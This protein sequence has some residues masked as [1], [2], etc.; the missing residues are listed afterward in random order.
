MITNSINIYSRKPH[1]PYNGNRGAEYQFLQ[2]LKGK[3]EFVGMIKGRDNSIYIRFINIL[4][5]IKSDNKILNAIE[6]TF[7]KDLENL[8]E[9]LNIPS[10]NKY[11]SIKRK[12][13]KLSDQ[14]IYKKISQLI[15]EYGIIELNINV[16]KE[17][18]SD[19]V[20]VE[21]SYLLQTIYHRF[22]NP[23]LLA[24]FYERFNKPHIFN[25]FFH[26]PNDL[27]LP[28]EYSM[29]SGCV[30]IFRIHNNCQGLLN[31]WNRYLPNKIKNDLGEF[32]SKIKKILKNDEH[33]YENSEIRN[34]IIKNQKNKYRFGSNHI[35]LEKELI[36]ITEGINK[37]YNGKIN[38]EILTI[39]NKNIYTFTPSILQG[40]ENI[41]NS[42]ADNSVNK[43]ITIS[44]KRFIGAEVMYKIKIVDIDGV[45]DWGT[46]DLQFSSKLKK[47][48]K[49]LRGH[50]DWHIN[51][52][53]SNSSGYNWNVMKNEFDMTEQQNNYIEHIITIYS[54]KL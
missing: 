37:D 34:E 17:I 18:F 4:N 19:D 50:A 40:L 28:E 46:P 23:K 3:I 24:Y 48:V 49:Y 8:F 39:D 5:E 43:N 22:L 16:S 47:A 7:T 53:L 21:R 14:E 44:S 13:K 30:D 9:S 38:F 26:G 45:F 6:F 33:P 27:D 12:I 25:G 20:L 51:A 32:L 29:E 11:S 52:K 54:P 41:I 1:F 10:I 2:M 31:V 36:F 15:S 42:M 35:N